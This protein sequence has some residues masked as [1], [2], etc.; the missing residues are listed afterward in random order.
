MTTILAPAQ[1]KPATCTAT[2]DIQLG[3]VTIVDATGGQVGYRVTSGWAFAVDNLRL[4][5]FTL[6][7]EW[8]AT[9][10][11]TL[12]VADVRRACTHTP[13]CPAADAPDRDAAHAV[14]YHPEQG[15][16]LL[17]NGVIEYDDTGET[18]PD[19]RPI[20]PHRPEVHLGAGWGV[21]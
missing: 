2:Y 16:T 19:G 17:C 5:G 20:A 12:F 18:L 4:E 3:L 14:S 10:V 11:P 15:W 21:A 6:A 9:A 7:G 1:V 8:R 13:P